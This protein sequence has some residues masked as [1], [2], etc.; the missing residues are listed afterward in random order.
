MQ[1]FHVKKG[2]EVVVI[3]G[4]A[5]GRRGVVRNV[6]SKR[7]S[8]ILES[9]DAGKKGEGDEAEQGDAAEKQKLIKPTIHYLRKSQQNPQGGLLWLEGP[10][11]VSKVMLA[12]KFDARAS[13]GGKAEKA[14]A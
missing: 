13:K 2:D 1:K 4:S 5:K 12:E 3:A 10:I 7:N 11:H 8:V 14:G 9:A 6:V